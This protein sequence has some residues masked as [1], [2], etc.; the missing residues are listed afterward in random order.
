MERRK[1][2]KLVPMAAAML[3][4]P[5]R[6]LAVSDKQI[7][8][9]KGVIKSILDNNEHLDRMLI[10]QPSVKYQPH[11]LIMKAVG[12]LYIRKEPVDLIT[13]AHELKSYGDLSKIG[14][15]EYLCSIMS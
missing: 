13:V 5:H 12:R 15:C 3:F 14:G 7:E 11:Q 4:I 8:V 10:G 1:F 6:L 9:E 2:L